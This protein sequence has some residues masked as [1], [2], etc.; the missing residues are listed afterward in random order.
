MG[1]RVATRMGGLSGMLAHVVGGSLEAPIEL[2]SNVFC[3]TSELL[4]DT[5]G[6]IHVLLGT[7]WFLHIRFYVCLCFL[8]TSHRWI[9]TSEGTLVVV[10]ILLGRA[11]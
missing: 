6:M 9:S 8:E 5:M 3:Q 10:H 7:V 2:N 1:F 11:S 4:Y